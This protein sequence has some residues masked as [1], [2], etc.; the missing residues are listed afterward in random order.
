MPDKPTNSL[1]IKSIFSKFF[2]KVVSVFE[3]RLLE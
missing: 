2:T 1:P 3:R